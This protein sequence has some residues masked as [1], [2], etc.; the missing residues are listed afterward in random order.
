MIL[1]SSAIL[2]ILFAEP[3]APLDVAAVPVGS[4]AR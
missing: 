2:A 3:D 1:D 4:E